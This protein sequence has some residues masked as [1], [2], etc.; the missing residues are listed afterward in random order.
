MSIKE[1]IVEELKKLT[2]EESKNIEKRRIYVN[3][4]E[5]LYQISCEEIFIDKLND[6]IE[7][8]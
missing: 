7:R 4:E 6:F 3:T 1:F 8:I 2:N 5:E